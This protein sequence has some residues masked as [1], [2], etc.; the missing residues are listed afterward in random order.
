MAGLLLPGLVTG[1]VIDL[2]TPGRGFTAGVPGGPPRHQLRAE[3]NWQIA[4]P[5]Q[6][7]FDASALLWH[8]GGLLTVSDKGATVYRLV[9]PPNTT[10]AEVTPVPAWFA[11]GALQPFAAAKTGRYDCEGLALDE[12]GRIYT[13][14]EANRWILRCHP[15]NGV[16]ER[17]DI[18]WSPVARFLH[19]TDLNASWEGI[20]IG[21][22]RLYVAN[23]RSLGRLVVV[24]LATLKVVDHFVV[25]PA[26]SA[27]LD[28]HYSGL[29]WFENSLWVLCR[30]S[31]MVLRVDPATRQ[32][33]AE[34]S[35]AT[36]E[37]D[38]EFRY[39]SPFTGTMEGLAVTATHFWLITDNNGKGRVKYPEDF[40]PTLFMCPRPDVKPPPR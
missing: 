33:L 10:W 20:A 18:D 24:D 36:M 17:L 39:R 7:P 19:Q 37:N 29:C 2:A 31:Q 22:G 13:C 12:Q 32:V 11:A 34:H 21:G 9:F 6:R 28:I 23:E 25:K 38:D 35:F 15:T 30:E 40:R 14:E 27:V 26:G 8:E 4:P 16:V 3:R 1:C 5:D